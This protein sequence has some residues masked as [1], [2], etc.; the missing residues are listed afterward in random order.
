[1]ICSHFS[2]GFLQWVYFSS[3]SLY[4]PKNLTGPDCDLS[5]TCWSFAFPSSSFCPLYCDTRA[6]C[7]IHIQML[8]K[9]AAPHLH[10]KLRIWS[11]VVCI[12]IRGTTFI[13][14]RLDIA[15]K[16]GRVLII[17]MEQVVCI[18]HGRNNVFV[19]NVISFSTL[20]SSGNDYSLLK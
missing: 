3:P 10:L 20:F 19:M 18:A 7:V 5:F 1:M 6:H 9:W 13:E 8:F 14:T 2:S 12:L 15:N 16:W 17:V 11:R 4:F